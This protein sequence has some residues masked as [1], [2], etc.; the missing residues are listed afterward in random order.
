MTEKEL[1]ELGFRRINVKAEDS[2]S[3]VDWYY[4][5][6]ILVVIIVHLI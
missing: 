1:I 6:Y 3:P 4:Y 5:E 2:I